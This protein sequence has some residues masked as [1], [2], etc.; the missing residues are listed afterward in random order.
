MVNKFQAA[1][2][3]GNTTEA[4][5]A[6][7][8]RL[9]QAPNDA[10]AQFAL[11]AVEFL[12]SVEH[13]GQG[14]HRYGLDSSYTNPYALALGGQPFLRLPVPENNHPD[15]VSYDSLRVLLANFVQDLDRADRTLAT[16]ETS[17]VVLPLNIGLVQFDFY[18]DGKADH[19]T[20]LWRAFAAVAY[21]G[22]LTES[23]AAKLQVDF[24]GSDVL[25]LRAYCHL[26]RAMA[27]FT[28]A[29]DWHEAYEATFHGVFPLADFPMTEALQI[30]KVIAEMKALEPVPE[31]VWSGA[32]GFEY[33][34]WVK[35]P[36]GQ[37]NARWHALERRLENGGIADLVAFVHLTHWPVVE[38]Q[39]LKAVNDDL[40]AMVRL[41]RQ[42]WTS[43]LAEKDS[44]QEW[45]PNPRQHGVLPKM[46]VTEERVKGWMLFLDEFEAILEGRKLIP[47]WRFDK[48]FNVHRFLQESKTFDLVLLIQG[49]TALPY[50]ET[51]DTTSSATWGTINRLLEGDLMQYFIWLN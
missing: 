2:Y 29:Y 27:E 19:A 49:S 8:S 46:T 14:L 22:A 31:F 48:G 10:Q 13:L 40:L 23:E 43:I 25:W 15:K 12:Q 44:G 11:G 41:S 39:R 36:E 51:G 1:L 3:A 35:S 26:L 6:A 17:N 42:S 9:S 5:A 24:D 4:A 33:D 34:A 38:S 32:T 30:P 21:S 47:H 7:E 18:G 28:L 45:I 20:A 37:K 50:L 16:V